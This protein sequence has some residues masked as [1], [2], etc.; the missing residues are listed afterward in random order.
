MTGTL[1]LIGIFTLLSALGD[2]EG[3]VHASKVWQDGRFVWSEAVKSALGFQFGVVMYWLALSKLSS[4][5][6][7]QVELQTMF[8]FVATIIGV[9]L[10]SGRILRWPAI[11]QFVA[12]G[13]LV[14]VGWL[15]SRAGRE[16]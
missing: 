3:F 2:A 16:V 5:G 8:W 11:D 1:V 12:V 4:I 6:V 15:L 13:V 9:A 10:I 7:V 14:G